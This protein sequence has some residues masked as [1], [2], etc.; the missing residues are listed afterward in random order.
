[1]GPGRGGRAAEESLN[2]V[3]GRGGR[4]EV[5]KPRGG[6]QEHAGDQVVEEPRGGPKRGPQPAWGAWRPSRDDP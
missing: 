5:P 4:G 3:E 2:H 1:M 6:H